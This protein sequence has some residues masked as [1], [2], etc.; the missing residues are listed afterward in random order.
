VVGMGMGMGF[1]FE[2]RLGGGWIAT[3]EYR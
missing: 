3:G 2:F 1:S